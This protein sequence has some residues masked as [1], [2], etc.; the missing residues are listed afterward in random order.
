M[1][2]SSNAKSGQPVRVAKS[3]QGLL[4]NRPVQGFP[5]HLIGH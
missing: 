4:S 1:S 3:H 5:G 2:T